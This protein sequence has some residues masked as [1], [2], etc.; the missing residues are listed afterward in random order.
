M[1]VRVKTQRPTSRPA[2][3]RVWRGMGLGV[4]VASSV[5]VAGEFIADC[6]FI[7]RP[8]KA[9]KESDG[10]RRTLVIPKLAD[11]PALDGKLDDA[12]WKQ[13]APLDGFTRARAE[14]VRRA[15]ARSVK[16]D[17][18]EFLQDEL[19]PSAGT[20]TRGYAYYT[21]THLW[22]GLECLE[23]QPAKI[24]VNT[25]VSNAGQRDSSVWQDD[26]VELFLSPNNDGLTAYQFGINAAGVVYDGR[27]TRK[28][29]SR[30]V[31]ADKTWNT[32]VQAKTGRTAQS[33]TLELAVP[34]ADLFEGDPTGTAWGLNIQRQRTTAG[35]SPH[36]LQFWSLTDA[37]AFPEMDRYG[38][39]V[40][41]RKPGVEVLE[42]GV[43]APGYGENVL[44]AR[45]LNRADADVTLACR[46][47]FEPEQG[48]PVRIDGT[49]YGPAGKEASLELPVQLTRKGAWSFQAE[50]R[51]GAR[52]IARREETFSI[53]DEL[54]SVRLA[55]SIYPL[56]DRYAKVR[57]RL[58]VAPVSLP[59]HALTLTLGQGERVVRRGEI[60]Q[61]RSGEAVLF[62][63]IGG[64][65]AG[66]YDLCTRLLNAEGV[67]VS[68]TDGRLVREKG[69]F[70]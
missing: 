17:P 30:S 64:L 5:C 35:R 33:W 69:P 51:A 67:T 46:A 2:W 49:L 66:T 24:K 25:A 16:A 44:V 58:N 56:G 6:E 50:L 20:G 52:L 42:L 3:G 8:A 37:S 19:T 13:A 7:E 18:A 63:D 54:L 38:L 62:L 59:T 9:G 14:A 55:D 47:V 12:V 31:K 1:S 28:P 53:P 40:F 39:L 70:D 22:L 15:T 65:A 43:V 45:A 32:D 10:P 23:P 34:L 68:E 48:E 36:E 11:V 41:A 26:D 29:G 4:V 61:V 27:N 60:R 57:L 21:G